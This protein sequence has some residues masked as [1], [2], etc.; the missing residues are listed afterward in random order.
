MLVYAI[1][2]LLSLGALLAR[3]GS[4]DLSPNYTSP[5]GVDIFN[6]GSSF[7]PTGTWSLMS[8][9]GSTLYVAGMRGIHPSNNS[10]AE[11][12]YP[13][14]RL[15]FENMRYLAR[16]G[17]S[18]L[19]GSVSEGGVSHRLMWLSDVLRATGSLCDGHV[20]LEAT[21]ESSPAGAVE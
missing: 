13:R 14:V 17:G 21:G 16:L 9:A 7:D 2:I 8:R 10:L 3:R 15:A 11:V 18:D 20:P 12:G 19:V 4:A 5:L 6:P 1:S